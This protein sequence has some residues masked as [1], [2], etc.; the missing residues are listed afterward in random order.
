MSEQFYVLLECPLLI[1][2]K[3]HSSL[4]LYHRPLEIV[5]ASP[6]FSHDSLLST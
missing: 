6:Y 1:S 3:A 2:F 4:V 5:T